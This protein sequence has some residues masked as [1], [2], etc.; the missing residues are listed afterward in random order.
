MEMMN[1]L[2]ARRPASRGKKSIIQLRASAA[3][4]LV[5]R[6]AAHFAGELHALTSPRSPDVEISA[7]TSVSARA[8]AFPQP[9][10]RIDAHSPLYNPHIWVKGRTPFRTCGPGGTIS[11]SRRR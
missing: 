9:R 10:Q 8:E 7:L 3:T 1:N 2:H 5:L 4:P 6:C 11:P